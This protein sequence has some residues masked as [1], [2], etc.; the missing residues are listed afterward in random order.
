MMVATQFLLLLVTLTVVLSKLQMYNELDKNE[1]NGGDENNN[2]NVIKCGKDGGDIDVNSI[3]IGND[4]GDD[5]AVALGRAL[6]KGGSKLVGCGLGDN[7]VSDRGLQALAAACST[8][9]TEL[10]ELHLFNNK[11]G[12]P[13]MVAL[14]TALKSGNCGLTVVDL[15]REHFARIPFV[16]VTRPLLSSF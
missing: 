16:A 12:D 14:A 11:I 1:I 3:E 7:R 10:K 13:G 9:G 8:G 2:N 6:Q 15:S 4:I 5:G